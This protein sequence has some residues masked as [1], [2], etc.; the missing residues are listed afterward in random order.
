[1][2]WFAHPIYSKEGG[3]PPIMIERIANISKE[4]GYNSSRLPTFTKEQIDYIRGKNWHIYII[5]IT[6][7][8][9]N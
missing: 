7:V 2:G 9:N 6:L 4:Q 1:M 3:Y 5:L 8:S